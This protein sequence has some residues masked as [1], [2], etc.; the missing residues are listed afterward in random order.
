LGER[1]RPARLRY[2]V[3]RDEVLLNIKQVDEGFRCF[4]VGRISGFGGRD[5][6]A[7][8]EADL[9]GWGVGASVNGATAPADNGTASINCAVG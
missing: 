1:G 2:C 9:A 5:A 8:E 3:S 6:R 7:P 4:V